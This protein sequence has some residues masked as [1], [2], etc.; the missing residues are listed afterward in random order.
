MTGA[1]L[2]SLGVASDAEEEEEGEEEG[3]L[4]DSLSPVFM[5]RTDGL[6]LASRLLGFGEEFSERHLSFSLF[7]GSL[8][9]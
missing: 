3:M 8:V 6:A 7:T 2:C 4:E 9:S 5:A 1:L